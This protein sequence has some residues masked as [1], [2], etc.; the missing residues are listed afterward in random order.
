MEITS[1]L[2][3]NGIEYEYADKNYIVFMLTPENTENDLE[4]LVSAFGK[5]NY[6]YIEK[7]PLKLNVSKQIMSIREAMFSVSETIDVDDAEN[8]ICTVPTVSCP[9]AI[10]VAVPGEAITKDMISVFKY[11]GITKVDVVK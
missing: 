11:Y 4:R 1:E 7:E 5:N 8:R 9:P 10:P 2:R 6:A 3:K